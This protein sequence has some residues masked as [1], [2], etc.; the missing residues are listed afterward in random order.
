[1]THMSKI[2]APGTITYAMECGRPLEV[3]VIGLREDNGGWMG[4]CYDVVYIGNAKECLDFGQ[5]WYAEKGM[6]FL[7][8]QV[9][10][11]RAKEL[12]AELKYINERDGKVA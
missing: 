9:H 4:A 10:I 6:R 1:M 2:I 8:H 11:D 5:N 3:C 12:I 7:A